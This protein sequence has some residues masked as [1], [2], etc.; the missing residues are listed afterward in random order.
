MLQFL[1]Q[2]SEYEELLHQGICFNIH[3]LIYNEYGSSDVTILKAALK[4]AA[5][6]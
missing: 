3:V 2:Y 1:N 4:G 5:M 6:A